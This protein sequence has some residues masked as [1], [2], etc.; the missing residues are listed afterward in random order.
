MYDK[1]VLDFPFYII[2]GNHD[3]RGSINAQIAYT[4]R[5]SRWYMPAL[6]YSFSE[7]LNEQDTVQFYALNTE[8]IIEGQNVDEQLEWFENT[9]SQC[10]P[11]ARWN[12]VFGHH[13]IYSNGQHGDCMRM[14]DS[15]LPILERYGVDIYICG[16]EHDLQILEPVNGVH[17]H[18][19]GAG[20]KVRDTLCKD[21]SLYAAGLL[22]FMTFRVS[23]DEVVVSV[24]LH[25]G[26][27]DYG[28]VIS[29]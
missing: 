27:T 10:A 15:V 14:I 21:N 6:Y 4:E 16:H 18:V 8:P 19:N 12:I 2:L 26:Q 28:Y 20:A 29:K 7:K 23:H 5:S 22:G 25:E 9:L 11:Q 13:P 3:Y 17:L 1:T 24:V